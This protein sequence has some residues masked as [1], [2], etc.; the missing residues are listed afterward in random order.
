MIEV[1]LLLLLPLIL[2]SLILLLLLIQRPV[3]LNILTC[4]LY[5]DT[6]KEDG[7]AAWTCSIAGDVA[8][9]LITCHVRHVQLSCQPINHVDV[10]HIKPC[11]AELEEYGTGVNVQCASALERAVD[12]ES[13][14]SA[15]QGVGGHDAWK[16]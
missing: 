4:H 14:T 3:Q 11:A 1:L 13:V 8:R 2:L 7:L 9:I 6:V 16:L 5:G 12:D 15:Y 10:L